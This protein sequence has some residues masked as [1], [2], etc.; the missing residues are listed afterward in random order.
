MTDVN[1]ASGKMYGKKNPFTL[2]TFPA[3]NQLR[4]RLE[5]L[6]AA[7]RQRAM[8]KLHSFDFPEHDLNTLRADKNGDIFY[9]DTELAKTGLP[10]TNSSQIESVIT[11]VDTFQLHSLP[12]ASKTVFLDFDGH[13]ITNTAW[14]AASGV[15][16]YAAVAFD[17]DGDPTSFSIDERNRIAETW[18][19]IAE[20]YASFDIDVTTEQPAAFGPTVGRLLFT[21]NTDGNGVAM[22]SQG[23]GGVAYVNVFGASNYASYYSPALVYFNQLGSGFAPYIAEA[24]SHEFGHNLGLSHDGVVDGTQNPKCLNT[25]AYYCGLGNGLSSWGAIMEVGYYTN[26]TEWSKGEYPSANNSQ[27][28][29]SV[30]G[31]K[32]TYRPDSVSNILTG[33]TPLA[34]N[35][36][37]GS[38]TVTTPETDPANSEWVNKG[39]IETATD[40]DYFWF[41]ANTGPINITVTPAWAAYTRSSTRGANLDVEVKLYDQSGTLIT[42]NSPSDDTFATL[43]TNVNAGRYYIAISGAGNSLIPYSDYGSLGEYFISGTITPSAADTTAPNPNPM[44]WVQA[45]TAVNTNSIAMTATTATDDSGVVE[46]Q[47]QCVA[48]GT[49]CVNSAWQSS[50]NYVVTGLSANTTYSFNVTARD[51][52]GN[53]TTASSA[54]SATTLANRAPIANGDSAVVNEDT[55]ITLSVLSNDSDPDG[56]SLT[57][58]SVG[59]PLHG[60]A[61]IISNTIRY[62]PA[63]NYFGSDSFSYTISDGF[64][65]TATATISITVNPV[66]DVPTTVA[67]TATVLV[68]QTISINVLANDSDIDGDSLT[69]SAVTRPTRGT[70]TIVNNALSFNASTK[71]GTSTFNYTVS[72]GKGGTKTASVTVTIK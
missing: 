20:D 35:P 28:D 68:R 23:A 37:N 45:P 48:G 41:D 57:I 32:L 69:L 13:T 18:H 53:V 63:A 58:S 14:N 50:P 29:L 6:P 40:V 65:S 49:G 54:L 43:A 44:T 42:T 24:A 19:R 72:D 33:A 67:D 51:P 30:I 31:S 52:S 17:L 47:F 34:I 4:K 22:P 56:N 10:L 39:I 25:T 60:T 27:D 66:N 2:N 71:K 7:A 70:A 15:A 5:A 11:P 16:S 38:I 64:G 55:S 9:N 46:Y 3:Q 26:V 36:S 62:Q 1:A 61:S 59:A 12:G 21:R 8:N